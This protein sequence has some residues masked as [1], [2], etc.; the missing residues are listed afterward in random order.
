MRIIVPLF[1]TGAVYVCTFE[2]MLAYKWWD[3]FHRVYKENRVHRL[4]RAVLFLSIH[5]S[6]R[7]EL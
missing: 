4:T 6:T 5:L 1:K 3:I 7:T 2:V